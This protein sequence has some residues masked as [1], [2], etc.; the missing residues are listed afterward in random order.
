VTGG[1]GSLGR[2]VVAELRRAGHSVRVLS[3]GRREP[4][5]QEPGVEHTKADLAVEGPPD[6]AID[7]IEVIVHLAGTAK[8]D[9][10][11]TRNLVRAASA[12]GVRHLVYISVVGADRVPTESLLDQLMF[13]YFAA[14][15]ESEQLIAN[16][17]LPWSTLRATQFYDAIYATA[18][19]MARMPV[20]PVPSGFRFQPVD[21]A[22]VAHRLVRLALG[23]PVGLVPDIGGPRIYEM[24]D[25][26]RSYLRAAGKHRLLIPMRLPG[27]A[28]AAHRDG[29]NLTP[30]RAVGVRTWEDY[31][32]AQMTQSGPEAEPSV[33]P[34]G[35]DGS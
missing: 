5:E 24:D 3:R 29:A 7:G 30:A 23:N 18:R 8:G 25:L 26:V 12:A 35:I 31:L 10:I 6:D 14:K 17:D 1:T 27:A 21:S 15:R 11:K 4:I 9:E 20:I 13:G 32:A 28:A 22:E 2:H 16:S 19:G 34:A 33:R